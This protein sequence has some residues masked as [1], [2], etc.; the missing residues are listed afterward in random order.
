MRK[1]NACPI[2]GGMENLEKDGGNRQSKNGNGKDF[3]K[4][5]VYEQTKL[6]G[7]ASGGY[8]IGRH[9]ECGKLFERYR[10]KQC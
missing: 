10:E 6:Q 9:P 3:K 1:R 2:P 5:E 4:E 7:I 8:L